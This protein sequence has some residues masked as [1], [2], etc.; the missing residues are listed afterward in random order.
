MGLLESTTHR[1]YY[2]NNTF[3]GYQFTSLDDIITQFQIA[4]VG[5]DKIISKTK[6]A[7]IAFHAQRALQELSFDTL[8]SI[9]S[10]QIELPPSLV[11]PLPHDYVNYTKI[12]WV[13]SAGVEHPL[14]HTSRTSNPFQIRQEE[15]GT[16]AFQ[17]EV[18]LIVNGDFSEA[19]A[20]NKPPAPW[21]RNSSP[22]HSSNLVADM[23]ITDE[24]LK[25][26]H[27]TRSSHGETN[28]GHAIAIWQEID[29]SDQDYIDISANG[30]AVNMTNGVGVLRFGV[31]TGPGDVNSKNITGVQASPTYN[32]D[33]TIFDL[34]NV[35]DVSSYLEWTAEDTGSKE[36]LQVDVRSHDIVY[37][38]AVSYM[39][40]SDINETLTVTNYIDDLSIED[41]Y[42]SVSLSGK[43][44]NERESSTW[45][46]YKSATPSENNNDDYEDD[47]YWPVN[48][49][50]YGLDPQHAQANGSFFI[51]PR[52]GRIHFSSNVSGKN[53]ILDYISDSLGTD[54][55][56]QV[57]KF[58]EEAMYK[59]IAYAIISTKINVPGQVVQR[60]KKEKFAE[61]R[62]AKL[63]L[64]NI[65]LEELTQTLRGKSKHI[66]H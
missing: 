62:K 65:K 15:D 2:Q 46:S 28:W 45:N 42:A 17:E 26:S 23:N 39:D 8:K 38:L 59:C 47:T 29:V 31:S 63:R 10:Y 22:T 49:E 66:K 58:A 52:L 64:S 37:A 50:R 11:M 48:G 57:H 13:D 54:A 55:E 4:Y 41:S 16:Y 7:D 6:R 32:T 30:T 21:N 14:Y 20:N 3:G 18:E 24:V 35:N 40:F 25:F 61:V 12:T 56:M 1:E 27:R 51:D 9:K 43:I 36:L 44:G 5:E 19:N 53:V 34:A 33:T 60:F